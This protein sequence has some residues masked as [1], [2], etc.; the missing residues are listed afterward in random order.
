[1]FDLL[2]EAAKTDITQKLLVFWIV[3]M[4]VRRTI[5]SHFKN[6]E[7]ALQ[8]VAKNLSELKSALTDHSQRLGRLETRV[9]TLE[10]K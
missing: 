2:S 10:K 1:M 3:W 6:V 8:L 7:D 5:S 9:E 4:I